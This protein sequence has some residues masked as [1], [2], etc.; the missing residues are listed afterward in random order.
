MIANVFRLSFPTLGPSCLYSR[1]VLAARFHD[2]RGLQVLCTARSQP[3]LFT[4]PADPHPT[5][6]IQQKTE[7]S[8]IHLVTP[9]LCPRHPPPPFLLRDILKLLRTGTKTPICLSRL[10]RNCRRGILGSI[11]I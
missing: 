3:I 8:I 1:D 10:S 5:V 6:P 4:L 11:S 2:L 9:A 7:E